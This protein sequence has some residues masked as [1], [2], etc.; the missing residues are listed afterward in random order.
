MDMGIDGH[1]DVSGNMINVSVGSPVTN[2]SY[3]DGKSMKQR[4]RERILS[5][6]SVMGTT[7]GGPGVAAYST[8]KA[9][10]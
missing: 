5:V 9:E 7:P 2:L 3:L 1:E 10:E 4:R 8:T 6:S